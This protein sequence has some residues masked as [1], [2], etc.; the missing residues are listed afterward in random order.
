V[1]VYLL[2]WSAKSGRTQECADPHVM[3]WPLLQHIRHYRYHRQVIQLAP[4]P[5]AQGW[6]GAP[7]GRGRRRHAWLCRARAR[8]R[9]RGAGAARPVGAGARVKRSRPRSRSGRSAEQRSSNTPCARRGG[10]AG[11]ARGSA[12]R[13]GGGG[14]GWPGCRLGVAAGLGARGARRAAGGGRAAAAAGGRGLGD[15]GRRAGAQGCARSAHA[16][17]TPHERAPHRR[18]P[19]AWWSPRSESVDRRPLQV[20]VMAHRQDIRIGVGRAMNATTDN[21]LTQWR[22]RHHARHHGMSRLTSCRLPR[23]LL[24]AP[25]ACGRPRRMP[26]GC[27][28]AWRSRSVRPRACVPGGPRS[29]RRRRRA[30]ARARPRS[31]RGSPR[32][33]R[34]VGRRQAEGQA[35]A[36]HRAR[37]A[38][39]DGRVAQV[40]RA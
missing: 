3:Q 22:V 40:L 11:R 33:C 15:G 23:S 6:C 8:M 35:P 26:R 16:S 20:E 27:A 37:P 2:W 7:A 29:P 36:L 14:L 24:R 25:Q 13:G 31:R 18:R 19:L 4:L 34:P 12:G 21:T 32:R 39:A 10:G 5:H 9:A 28:M 17:S 1:L 30:S 38:F